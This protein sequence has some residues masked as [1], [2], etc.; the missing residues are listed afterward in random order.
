[1]TVDLGL[2]R[3]TI[4]SRPVSG[5][6]GLGSVASNVERVY[7]ASEKGARGCAILKS[8]IG[9]PLKALYLNP[10]DICQ[11]QKH[12]KTLAVGSVAKLTEHSHSQREALPKSDGLATT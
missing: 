1:V 12:R 7:H 10:N 8:K 6:M 4:T 2:G 5:Y 11:Q 9:T 3:L